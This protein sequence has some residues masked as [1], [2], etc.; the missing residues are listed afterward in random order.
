MLDT[1]IISDL[2]L[3][4]Q[5]RDALDFIEQAAYVYGFDNIKYAGDI[6]D[7]HAGSF[8]DVEYG[9]LSSKEEYEQSY[10]HIQHLYTLFPDMTIVKGN[11][12]IIPERQ[13]KK[14]GIAQDVIKTFTD[15][16]DVPKWNFV[17]KELF[18]ITKDKQC[19]LVHTMGANTLSNARSHSHCSIQGHH[20]SKFGIEYYTDTNMIRWSMTVGCLVDLHHPA[21][22]YASSATTSRPI[23]GM[24]CIIDD[25]PRL[26]PMNLKA[27]GR[28][29]GV[30]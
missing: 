12:D 30:V 18:K 19:L 11:H 23:L 4:Y 1:L 29:D 25:E 6:V 21:F 27:N 15:L 2:H 28:W 5:H 14:A 22:N 26:L 24:G 3:P 10:E 17:E 20:H 13:A 16:Y 7:N 8:H 9:V